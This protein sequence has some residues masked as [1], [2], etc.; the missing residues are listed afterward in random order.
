MKNLL[1]LSIICFMFFGCTTKR[2]YFTPENP[3]EDAYESDSISD[4]VVFVTKNGAILDN[5]ELITKNGI[6]QDLKLDEDYVFLGEYEKYYILSSKDGN[7]K[8]TNGQNVVYEHKFS[9][10]I[11]SASYNSGKLAALDSTNKMYLID[12]LNNTFLTEYASGVTFAQNAIMASPLFLGNVVVYPTLD[13]KVFIIDAKDGRIIRNGVVSSE[14]FFN[15]IIFLEVGQDRLFA[16][17]SNRILMISPSQNK[18]F[19]AD[20]RNI[21][22]H[23][24]KLYV[25]LKDGHINILDFDLNKIAD[26]EFKF[27]MF[28]D[29]TI[30]KNKLYVFEKTGYLIQTDLNLENE[31]VYK[32]DDQIDTKSFMGNKA[33]YYDDKI[34][35]LDDNGQ[36]DF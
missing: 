29:A 9:A 27:A 2:Q 1:V 32:L 30:T 7:L 33:F 5:G 23:D 3:I 11:I 12:T 28:L 36:F 13:G 15:N 8:I 6:N 31:V 19:S 34:I 21:L 16:A 20:I 4:D 26:K 17:T 22:L 14:Y 25:L 35:N 24:N 18:Y 10:Q